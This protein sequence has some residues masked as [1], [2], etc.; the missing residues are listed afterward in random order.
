MFG[1]HRIYLKIIIGLLAVASLYLNFYT[2]YF[3]DKNTTK[4]RSPVGFQCHVEDW[5]KVHNNRVPFENLH[6]EWV[7]ENVSRRDNIM[8]SEIR[9]LTAF[10]YESYISITT[11]SQRSFG[12]PIFCRYYDCKREEIPSSAYSSFFFPMNVV[13]CPRRVGVMY[14]SISNS[15][16]E[17]PQDPIPL[18]FRVYPTPVHEISVCVGPMYGDENKWLEVAEFVEHYKLLGVRHF[19]FTI[20]NMKEYSRKIMDEY[21]RTGEIELTVIQS[22]YANVDWQFHLL[23]I[24]E[25]HQRSKYHSKW[26]INVDVD[27]RLIMLNGTIQD[28]IRG[29]NESVSEAGFA[30]QRI[31]KTGNL[32]EKYIND[33][34]ITSEMEFL[35]YNLSAKV[36]WAAYKSM[37]RPEKTAAMYF[38][39]AYKRYP[40]NVVAYVKDTTSYIRH[41]RT[42]ENK[43]LGIGWVDDY[44][45]FTVK[46]KYVYD[47]RVLNCEEIPEEAYN[48]YKK[49]GHELFHCKFRNETNT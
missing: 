11:T 9:L 23:Q 18:I 20:F 3:I 12:Q 15:L 30:V 22:E 19:Y 44:G 5:N 41:Y 48:E 33:E 37:Y 13:Q 47:Q 34:Q 17:T 6:L 4:S 43:G 10:V 25:C 21:L 16:S 29:Y 38:H 28:V 2:K 35:K 45:N 27:E 42:I 8:G 39:W 46:I 7:K 26:V 31:Q 40:N 1:Y 32:P 49:F 24:N 36:S 14:V